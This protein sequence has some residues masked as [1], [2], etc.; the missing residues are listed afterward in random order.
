MSVAAATHVNCHCVVHRPK[1]QLWGAVVARA[2]IGDVG[3][4][5]DQGLG[6]A[7]VTQL[8]C[9]R[10]DVHQQVLGLDVP[11]GAR[12]LSSQTQTTMT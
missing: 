5:A 1:N 10:V 3:L 6:R 2:D 4:A 9:M 8:E 11:A 12:W 7:K